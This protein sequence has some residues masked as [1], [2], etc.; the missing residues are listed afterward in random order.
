MSLSG[1]WHLTSKWCVDPQCL[2]SV[3][4]SL[5]TWTSK[6]RGN[7]PVFPDLTVADVEVDSGGVNG[8]GTEADVKEDAKVVTQ[9]N[10]F[11]KAKALK[12]TMESAV[13]K[14]PGG[15]QH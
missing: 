5:G 11:E 13:A 1:G 9:A 8:G 2:V 6:Q 12:V 4:R 3:L 14:V 15:L 10:E 7:R